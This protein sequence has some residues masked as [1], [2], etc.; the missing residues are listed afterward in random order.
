MVIRRKGR[1]AGEWELMNGKPLTS[2]PYAFML[3][4]FLGPLQPHSSPDQAFIEERVKIVKA[5]V[6][7][8][9]RAH[10]YSRYRF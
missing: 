6:N 2:P 9:I 8:P 7:M 10:R 3:W 5:L 4:K 1:W